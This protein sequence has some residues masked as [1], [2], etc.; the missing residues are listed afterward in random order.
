M[1]RDQIQT[2]HFHMIAIPSRHH[3]WWRRAQHILRSNDHNLRSVSTEAGVC[4]FASFWNVGGATHDFRRNLL[5]YIFSIFFVVGCMFSA[6]ISINK[7]LITISQN[8]FT[9]TFVF[10]VQNLSCKIDFHLLSDVILN[11]IWVQLVIVYQ[12]YKCNA[13]NKFIHVLTSLLQHI[14]A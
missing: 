1:T 2:A 13:N 5:K 12:Y 11:M 4:T 9:T 14:I 6:L 8:I 10:D 3:A 7:L